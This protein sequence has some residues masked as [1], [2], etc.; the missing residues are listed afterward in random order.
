MSVENK[1]I[2]WNS[3]P[4]IKKLLE[5]K[6]IDGALSGLWELSEKTIENKQKEL[7]WCYEIAEFTRNLNQNDSYVEWVNNILSQFLTPQSLTV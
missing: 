2:T 1:E 7:A 3:L 6:D 5:N 4:D